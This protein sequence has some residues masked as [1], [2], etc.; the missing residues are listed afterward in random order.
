MIYTYTLLVVEMW[1]L[2]TYLIKGLA[3]L[4]W[5]QQHKYKKGGWA[6]RILHVRISPPFSLSYT[7]PTFG[8]FDTITIVYSYRYRYRYDYRYRYLLSLS[9]S[10]SKSLKLFVIDIVIVIVFGFD[11]AIEVCFGHIVSICYLFDMHYY[12]PYL[13][14]NRPDQQVSRLFGAD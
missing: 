2:G 5:R 4:A 10:I 11:V 7:V 6:L 8:C 3:L 9:L 14:N 12:C 13:T 1:G